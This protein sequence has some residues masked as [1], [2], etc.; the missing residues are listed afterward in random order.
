LKLARL[1]SDIAEGIAEA[2]RGASVPFDEAA[3]ERIKQRGRQRLAASNAA[4]ETERRMDGVREGSRQ[5]GPATP[6][7]RD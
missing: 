4:I 2:D 6:E 5:E 7:I 3:A 1:R